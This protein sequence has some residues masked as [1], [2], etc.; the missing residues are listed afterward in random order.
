MI[1]R[2]AT[3]ALHASAGESQCSSGEWRCC[4]TFQL[5]VINIH[6]DI[7]A[8]MKKN[9][10]C[11]VLIVFLSTACSND[12]I[13]ESDIPVITPSE[14][15]VTIDIDIAIDN[16]TKEVNHILSNARLGF[17][18]LRANVRHSQNSKVKYLLPLPR[19]DGPYLVSA[20][21]GLM[22]ILIQ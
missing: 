8:K 14:D 2:A 7:S 5:L 18:P 3:L 12:E 15:G 9:I 19:P 11:L 4:L 16:V 1:F 17:F 20:S 13:E 6:S 10:V 22:P 21:S